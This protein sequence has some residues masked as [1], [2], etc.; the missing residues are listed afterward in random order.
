M[1]T[2]TT[3]HKEKIKLKYDRLID[4]T[5]FKSLTNTN[6]INRKIAYG[7]FLNRIREPLI[8]NEKGN[9]GGFIGGYVQDR[10]NKA[11]VKSRSIILID[12]DEVPEGV[13]V[14]ENIEGFTNFAVAMYS[15]HNHTKENPRYRVVIPLHHDIEPE[16]YK[17]VTQYLVDILQVW[18]DDTSCEF[19]RHM[20]YPTCSHLDNYEFYY[21]DLPFFDASFITKQ[22]EEIKAFKENKK[23]D[24]RT[25]QNWIGAWTNIYSIT[26]VLDN[27][28]SDKYEP[29]RNN[30]YTYI[31]GSSKG[32]LIVYDD[33][34]HAHSNHSTDPI[35]GK[36]VN[37]FDLYRLHRFGHLDNGTEDM[38]DKPSY[39][40]MIEHCNKDEK[41]R[42]YYEEHI[43]F[44]VEVKDLQ[45]IDLK[46]ELRDRYFEELSR[47]EQEWE[48]NG[49]KGRKPT[50]ISPARCSVILPEYISFV[51]FD[52]E[53]NTRLAMY[54]PEEGVYTQNATVIKRVISWLEPKLNNTKAEE[55]I[56]HLTNTAEVKGKTN[57]RYL[58]PVKNGV[59]NLKTKKLESF[60]ADYVFTTKITTP[61]IENPVNPVLDGWDVVS[62]M[63]SIAC[64]DLE[65]ENLLWQVMNDALNGNYSRRKSIFLIGEGNNGKGTFQELIMNL[66]GIK[67]IATLK[68]NEFDERFR[69][70]VLEGKTAVIGDDVPANVYIDDSSNFNSVV[71]GDMVSVEFKNRPIYNTVFRCS[72][73][74]STNGMPKF[75]NKTNGTIRR[76]VIVP[77]KADF[78]GAAEN[79]KIKDEYIKNEKVLQFVLCK[80]INMD[81]EKF[82]I[83]K[84]SLQELEVFKQDND[85]VLDFKLSVFDEWGI[86][87]VPKYIVY[88]FYKNFCH[89]NGYKHLADRQFHKQ[90]K[91]YLGDGWEDSQK[92]FR[93]ESLIKY[94]GD[95]DK[96]N[97]GFG[98]P[99][100]TKPYKAYKNSS[101]KVV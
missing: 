30:R 45:V 76:I 47:L 88:G 34:T 77:F 41:V 18:I 26:D 13:N 44:E 24:P 32:G 28:L 48:D 86:Q 59:F 93:Y 81:F 38:K 70:S 36:N 9:A 23:V 1:L 95:L 96:M 66:I 40:A 27:F 64:G 80:A 92:K 21:Q 42:E 94:V 35:S 16:H 14:W 6:A 8:T 29:F 31:A 50:T 74:Q 56:Y 101:F 61:Y 84:V 51:L 71:T 17:E 15:T 87:E 75:K 90:F 25:K 37:S 91:T 100:K 99:D 82:D 53:E 85:P 69:L 78:N 5:D 58:I 4:I 19:E 43:K 72:V 55:V 52:L 54:L 62:W 10:R 67:N 79:F 60:T 65:I 83:P 63:Q 39:R 68:V 73:I 2:I 33:A 89:E 97:L 98:F 3:A 22:H 11:N 57:S 7:E 20:H 49:K 46:K 12:I